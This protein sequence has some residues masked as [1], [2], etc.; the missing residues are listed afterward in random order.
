MRHDFAS[1]DP[2]EAALLARISADLTDRPAYDAY[3][4]WLAGRD[5]AA[6]DWVR[7]YAEH[8]LDGAPMPEKPADR[9][10]A[11]YR[12]LGG[13][14]YARLREL[15]DALIPW[16]RPVVTIDP[17]PC[18]LAELPLGASRFMG[19][20]DLPADFVWPTCAQGSLHFQAQI[21]LADLRSSVATSRF[22][23]PAAAWLVLFALDDPDSG[24]QP[25]VIDQDDDGNWFEPPGLTHLA[26]IPSDAALAR[27]PLPEEI[28]LWDDDNHSCVLA[29]A[30]CLDIPW[31]ADTE[32]SSLMQEAVADR[33]SD[34]RGSWMSKLMGYP[35]HGR[36]DNTS[37]GPDWLAVFTLGSHDETEW[38]WCDG[39]HLD[40]YVRQD[41]VANASFNPVYGY[42]S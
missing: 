4:T 31:A 12:M 17:R 34:L 21:N 36:T 42:A 26:Y 5:T 20:P 38:S 3:A 23:L 15:P 28:E 40:V 30:E 35:V 32:D 33:I 13:D 16:V 41:G 1:A 37:P 24:M 39:E 25:G 19:F 10:D 8:A 7:A 18:P 14:W 2:E 29:F 6:A 27:R 22:E 11:W 9:G